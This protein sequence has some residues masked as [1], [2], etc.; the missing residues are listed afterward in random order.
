MAPPLNNP[1]YQPQQQNPNYQARNNDEPSNACLYV[2]AVFF[3][4]VAVGIKRGGCSGEMWLCLLLS[5]FFYIPGLI[6]AIYII[7]QDS[8]KR[9]AQ[10]VEHMGQGY[11]TQYQQQ[12]QPIQPHYNQ[13]PL[14]QQQA[15]PTEGTYPQVA[16]A[17]HEPAPMTQPPVNQHSG[18][19]PQ[20]HSGIS[21]QAPPP[22]YAEGPSQPLHEKAQ[23]V[24]PN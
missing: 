16:P 2:L 11:A 6:Y 18:V 20:R 24:P 1:N 9:R 19:A 12:P 5:Y 23:Y 10:D 17:K 13:Q 8:D 21:P 14:H 22:T 15:Y 4:F 3:P 7:Q